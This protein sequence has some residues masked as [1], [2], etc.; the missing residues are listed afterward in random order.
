MAF[1]YAPDVHAIASQ[2]FDEVFGKPKLPVGATDH[3]TW[4]RFASQSFDEVFGKFKTKQGERLRYLPIAASNQVP[5]KA[6]LL[7]YPPCS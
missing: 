5:F 4:T 3:L 1:G 2:S 7:K 6:F